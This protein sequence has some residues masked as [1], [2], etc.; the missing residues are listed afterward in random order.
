M[1]SYYC[2]EILGLNFTE[3]LD[4]MR[5]CWREYFNIAHRDFTSEEFA[6]RAA[7]VFLT[8]YK[9]NYK[10]D[11]KKLLDNIV[12]EARYAYRFNNSSHQLTDGRFGLDKSR[13]LEVSKFLAMRYNFTIKQVE[14]CKCKCKCCA[15]NGDIKEEI[16]GSPILIID[17]SSVITIEE[18]EKSGDLKWAGKLV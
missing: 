1:D 18:M 16:L 7:S 8:S 10:S 11:Y 2:V 14:T 6:R 17:V 15:Q 12:G 9:E 5:E 4:R 3:E 13:A